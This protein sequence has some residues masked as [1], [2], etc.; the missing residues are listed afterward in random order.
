MITICQAL[1]AKRAIDYVNTTYGSMQG[2]GGSV[3]VVPPMEIAHAYVAPKAGTLRAAVGLPVFVAGRI[4]Q[5][6]IAERCSPPDRP[7]C[8]A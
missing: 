3:H 7:T 1:K 4:N 8:A 6:Q 2:L 5:P